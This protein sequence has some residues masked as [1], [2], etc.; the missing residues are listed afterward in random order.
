MHRK[1]YEIVGYAYD[2]DWHC[3]DCT[4]ARFGRAV[5]ELNFE[6]EDSEGNPVH[7]IL[8]GDLEGDE[9]CGDCLEPIE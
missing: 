8:L 9:V 7:P 5:Y 2:A 6:A 3:V 4:A 1:T